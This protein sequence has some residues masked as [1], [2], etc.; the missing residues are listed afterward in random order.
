MSD[1]VTAVALW[2]DGT[3]SVLLAVEVPPLVRR[4]QA[5]SSIITDGTVDPHFFAS[6]LWELKHASYIGPA[7]SSDWG[8]LQALV[9]AHDL[10]VSRGPANSYPHAC[11]FCG[12]PSYQG[13]VPGSTVDCSRQC[14]GSQY[15]MGTLP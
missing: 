10:S 9:Y 6:A 14:K 4:S 12:A 15:G 11:P 1:L 13:I 7:K 5:C 3:L 2:T 8:P